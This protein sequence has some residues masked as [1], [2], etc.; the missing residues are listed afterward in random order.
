M[1]LVV[2][3]VQRRVPAPA[4]QAGPRAPR[5]RHG[6]DRRGHSHEHGA[7]PEG[8]PGPASDAEGAHS[9]RAQSGSSPLDRALALAHAADRLLEVFLLDHTVLLEH[10]APQRIATNDLNFGVAKTLHGA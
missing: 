10:A 7:S 2:V 8:R 9:P 5:D 1:L 6:S 3:P 4:A